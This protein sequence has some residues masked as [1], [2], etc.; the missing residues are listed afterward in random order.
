M[1]VNDKKNLKTLR[2]VGLRPPS[3]RF[4]L[5]FGAKIQIFFF[6]EMIPTRL[7][8]RMLEAV[9]ARSAEM[10]L[11]VIMVIGNA[12]SLAV[13]NGIIVEHLITRIALRK[14]LPCQEQVPVEEEVASISQQETHVN[15]IIVLLTAVATM[16]T[17]NPFYPNE[18]EKNS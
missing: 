4:R 16:S 10:A 2:S 15:S 5:I 18:T 11:T 13:I 8:T 17:N 3:L 6:I 1:N 12:K 14:N 7:L 9:V